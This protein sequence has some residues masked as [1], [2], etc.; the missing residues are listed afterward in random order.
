MPSVIHITTRRRF[1][2][3]RP[4]V[5]VHTAPLSERERTERAGVPVT[6]VERTIT[7][8]LEHSGPDLATQAAEQALE[9]GLVTRRA[10]RTTFESYD[11]VPPP[12]GEL[13]AASS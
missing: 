9:R 5:T 2:G 1:R 6:A 3:R 8:L 4:G 11:E 13:T 10:L 12:L 7:D